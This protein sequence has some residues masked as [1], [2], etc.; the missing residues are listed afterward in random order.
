MNETKWVFEL[1]SMKAADEDRFEEIKDIF[2]A[3]R[4]SLISILGLNVMPTTDQETGI[5]SPPAADEF[6]PMSLVVG[7][8]EWVM[9]LSE[10]L[11]EM[12]SQ[13]KHASD[14]NSPP[15]GMIN[16]L[17][18]LEELERMEAED[19]DVQFVNNKEDLKKFL[20]WNSPES[21]YIRENVILTEGGNENHEPNEPQENIEEDQVKPE[22][23]R[24]TIDD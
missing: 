14:I 23:N 8:R 12:M 7:R 15:S 19:G 5:L 6:I 21:K 2:E 1:E 18:E 24:I 17:E 3:F 13:N 10:K 22:K 4:R 20:V 16:T 11:D 9:S